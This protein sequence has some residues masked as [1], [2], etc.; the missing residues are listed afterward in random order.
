M[1]QSVALVHQAIVLSAHNA[2]ML[3]S[4]ASRNIHPASDASTGEVIA[5]ALTGA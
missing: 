3:A 1:R 5:Y 2:R 4:A